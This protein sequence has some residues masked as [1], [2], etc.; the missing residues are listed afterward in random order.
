MIRYV[1]FFLFVKL[2]YCKHCK[3]YPKQK[4]IMGEDLCEKDRYKESKFVAMKIY[5]KIEVDS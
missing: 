3:S 4:L 5:F 2:R 1:Q